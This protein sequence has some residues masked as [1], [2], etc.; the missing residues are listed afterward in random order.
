VLFSKYANSIS[1]LLAYTNVAMSQA[2]YSADV[3]LDSAKLCGEI[4]LKAKKGRRH[5]WEESP[6][7]E[8][9]KFTYTPNFLFSL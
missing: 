2:K 4:A 7:P 9:N 8:Q 6:P 3:Q 5:S 1:T